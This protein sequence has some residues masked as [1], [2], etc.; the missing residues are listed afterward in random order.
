MIGCGLLA[1]AGDCAIS[2]L[3]PRSDY[4]N[5]FPPSGKYRNPITHHTQTET[6]AFVCVQGNRSKEKPEVS[7]YPFVQRLVT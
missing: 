1:M 7:N 4:P 5:G 3:L 6:S 2:L